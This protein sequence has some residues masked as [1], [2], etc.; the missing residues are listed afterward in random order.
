MLAFDYWH[1]LHGDRPLPH[2]S[3]L[4]PAGLKPFKDSSLLL[5]F[6]GDDLLVRFCGN[7]VAALVGVTLAP[8]ANLAG[9][10]DAPFPLALLGRYGD[11]A[12]REEAAEFEFEDGACACRGILLPFSAGGDDAELVLV[13]VD[14]LVTAD[15]G[16]VTAEA[17]AAKAAASDAAEDDT[18]DD[19][20]DIPAD[21]SAIEALADA[22]G[23]AGSA[24]VHPGA[25]T[26][27]GL[28]GALAQAFDFHHKASADP[29]GYQAFLKARGLRQQA[30]AP[31]T[32]ALKLTFGTGY[33]KTRLTE[34]AAAL[35]H[36]DRN[37]VTADDLP[38]FLKAQP[39]GIKGC[40]QAER[41]ERRAAAPARRP[42]PVAL[43][44][45][46]ARKMLGRPLEELEI[47]QEFGLVL[48]RRNE[49]G[50]RDLLSAVDAGE[51]MLARAL[52]ALG[53]DSDT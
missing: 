14:P 53:T 42:S 3:D 32:P 16:S 31:Y 33:D 45:D 39:G 9:L 27:D 48:V 19:A 28:Y 2:F 23:D 17:A 41:A 34:Y 5:E 43:A 51:H 13:V 37:G 7:G 21:F 22:C 30:R 6:R 20:G 44:Q 50:S 15:M 11:G 35:A 24:V 52:R 25:A 8:G 18:A 12:M 1:Q 40:V 38:A 29:D 26:R 4:T 47:A 10:G 46:T 49:D 36:A